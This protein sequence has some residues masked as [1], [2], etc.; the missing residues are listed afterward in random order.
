M[1][2]RKG[3]RKRKTRET[4]IDL[5]LT[6]DGRGKSRINCGLPFLE[7]M[8]E[9]FTRHGLFD[10]KVKATGDIEVDDH[11]L[12]ED[13]GI[14]LGEAIKNGLG[15]KEGI[16]RYGFAQ[17]PMDE[18]LV[19]VTVDLSGRSFFVYGVKLPAKKVKNFEV[20]LVEEFLRAVAFGA[21]MNLHVQMLY[22]KNT[23]H[24]IEGIFKALGRA[25]D[26]A[27]RTDPRVVGVPS[28]KGKL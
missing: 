8:L 28:T 3:T 20:Q 15:A 12:V 2:A 23:H 19:N 4:N 17:V 10:L 25:L 1:A 16:V 5:E 21:E 24:I 22:G 27:T 6:I 11:H 18:A 14:C 9:L 26:A 13:L 7:H